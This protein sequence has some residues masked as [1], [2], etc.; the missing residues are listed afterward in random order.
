MSFCFI[1]KMAPVGANFTLVGY[2]I[3]AAPRNVYFILH[4][5]LFLRKKYNVHW[6]ISFILVFV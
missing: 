4:Y 6:N 2:L 1:T 5:Q 3:N